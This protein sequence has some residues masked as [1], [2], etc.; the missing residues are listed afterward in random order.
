MWEDVRQIG[1]VEHEASQNSPVRCS[2]YW[3]IESPN[4][5]ASTPVNFVDP[6]ILR[7]KKKVTKT[8]DLTLWEVTYISKRSALQ[9][10]QFQL[11]RNSLVP[12]PA[13]RVPTAVIPVFII[14][15]S[16]ACKRP[17]PGALVSYACRRLLP[18]PLGS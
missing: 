7:I 6:K 2:K 16:C 10:S 11:S 12:A 8:P 1:R 3:S 17:L 5:K 14:F 13:S 18:G 4:Q 9:L 15:N